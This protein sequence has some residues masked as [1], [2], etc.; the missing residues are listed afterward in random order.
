M[1]IELC[2]FCRIVNGQSDASVVYRDEQVVAFRDI[3]P[4]APIHVLIVTTKHIASL[5]EVQ[6]EDEKLLMQLLA[7]A[8]RIAVQEGIDA[9]G[10]RLVLNSGTNAGQSVFHLHVHL[11]GGRGMHW[12]PG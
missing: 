10:Y 4:V 1:S 3:H 8:R 9:D 2:V 12:P 6:A 5:N 7:V 11:M